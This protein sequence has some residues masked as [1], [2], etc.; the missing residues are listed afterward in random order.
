[1]KYL[2]YG[3]HEISFPFFYFLNILYLM[4]YINESY[5]VINLII[6]F[7]RYFIF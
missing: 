5:G 2:H 4:I 6:L 1:M 7:A 3:V